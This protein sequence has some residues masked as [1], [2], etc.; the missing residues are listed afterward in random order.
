MKYWLIMKFGRQVFFAD[1]SDGMV[2]WTLSKDHATMVRRRMR[3]GSSVRSPEVKFRSS[4]VVERTLRNPIATA[5]READGAIAPA[6][7]IVAGGV[8]PSMEGPIQCR[9]TRSDDPASQPNTNCGLAREVREHTNQAVVRIDLQPQFGAA[10]GGPAQIPPLRAV[11]ARAIISDPLSQCCHFVRGVH[12]HTD[13]RKVARHIVPTSLLSQV[14]DREMRSSVALF[15]QPSMAPSIP[16]TPYRDPPPLPITAGRARKEKGPRV[17]S[18]YMVVP[19]AACFVLPAVCG[20]FEC[21]GFDPKRR[22]HFL[23]WH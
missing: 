7:Q 5:T 18:A 13:G 23:A 15:S 17:L 6:I 11:E 20:A 4:A 19:N 12:R 22:P 2:R 3:N 10:G 1:L 9:S 21:S 8:R 16:D 14:F